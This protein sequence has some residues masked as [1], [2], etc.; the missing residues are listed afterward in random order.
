MRRIPWLRSGHS[1]SRWPRG[2]MSPIGAGVIVLTISLV[3]VQLE[4]GWS[5]AVGG[6]C[7]TRDWFFNGAYY[8]PAESAFKVRGVKA[9]VSFKDSGLCILTN[10]FTF[11]NSWT[12]IASDN[13]EGWAQIGHEHGRKSDGSYYV[14]FFWQ[15]TRNFYADPVY[16]RLWGNPTLGSSYNLKVVRNASSGHLRML[17]DGADPPCRNSDNICPET[18]FDPLT[19]WPGLHAELYQEIYHKENDF[20]GTNSDRTVFANVQYANASGSW[21]NKTFTVDSPTC[22]GQVSKRSDTKFEAWTEPLDHSC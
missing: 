9:N 12:M 21:V 10:P 17:L 3:G 2:R 19:A 18:D 15:W 22:F 13:G 11:S 16:T 4:P 14:S 1:L 8:D 7:D 5:W 6:S 20:A